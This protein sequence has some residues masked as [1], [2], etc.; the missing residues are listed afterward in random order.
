MKEISLHIIDIVE[1][2]VSAGA[3]FVEVEI[4]ENEAED[5]FRLTVK[6]NGEGMNEETCKNALIP[7]FTGKPNEGVGLGIPLLKNAAE[8]TGGSFK[9]LSEIGVGTT[10]TAV[11]VHS[12]TSRQPLGDIVQ[13]MLNIFVGRQEVD[14][15]YSHVLND[16]VFNVDTRTIKNILG[17]V[18]LL[19]NDVF[20]WLKQ[21]L[22]EGEESIL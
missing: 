8:L 7:F 18:N 4:Y 2:A 15:K 17:D 1:N 9:I 22:K 6:D 20:L 14:F 10:I 3:S 11:F 21:Y 13:T 12:S 5:V 19:S 16:K